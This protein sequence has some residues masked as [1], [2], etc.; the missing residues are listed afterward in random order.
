MEVQSL[1][2]CRQPVFRL[3]PSPPIQIN[4]DPDI[5]ALFPSKK[6]NFTLIGPFRVADFMENFVL[7]LI[8][9]IKKLFNA[10]F[11][12][13]SPFK[14]IRKRLGFLVVVWKSVC[15]MRLVLLHLLSF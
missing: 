4:G 10:F 3:R 13:L 15:F 5:R 12:K 6:L 7:K 14:N 1:R 9:H 2:Q 11:I 8:L